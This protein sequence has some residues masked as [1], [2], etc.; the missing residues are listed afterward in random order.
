MCTM[1][2]PK[3]ALDLARFEVWEKSRTT[4]CR[5]LQ[6]FALPDK[7][8]NISDPEGN[9][10]SGTVHH[11]SG[12]G[13]FALTRC[14][15]CVRCVCWCVVVC[16]RVRGCGVSHTLKI[17]VYIYILMYMSVSSLLVF[18]WKENAVWNIY[19][20]WYLLFEAFD[21]PQWFHVICFSYLLQALSRLHKKQCSLKSTKCM[22]Q[23]REEK[24]WNHYKMSK[25]SDA[26]MYMYIFR[27]M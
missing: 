23:L 18:S 22:I 12:P 6:S 16:G 25:K 14:A 20:P 2:S 1:G 9:K 17:T 3:W 24:T 21:L 26:D 7:L 8:F 10:L 11:L 4:C 13:M 15:V 27:N 19:F 5:F